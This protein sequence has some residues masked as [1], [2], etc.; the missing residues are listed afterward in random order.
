MASTKEG[1]HGE[2]IGPDVHASPNARPPEL[3][4]RWSVQRKQ[5]IV[6]RLLRGEPLD[7]VSRETQVPAHDLER[8]QRRFLEAGQ[9]RDD[10][11][12]VRVSLEDDAVLQSSHHDVVKGVWRLETRLVR[13]DGVEGAERI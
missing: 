12:A 3:W 10:V 2:E 1:G 9:P 7:Q 8:W 5:E 11:L 4:E 13:Q 6:L